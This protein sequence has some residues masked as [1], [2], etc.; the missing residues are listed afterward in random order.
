MPAEAGDESTQLSQPGTIDV[1]PSS[2][3]KC[4]SQ[5]T[6]DQS[7]N[8]AESD[9]HPIPATK[10]HRS[11]SKTTKQP[12]SNVCPYSLIIRNQTSS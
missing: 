9:S 5:S 1:T 2:V 12:S 3:D 4:A 10:K 11:G 8:S 7:E 6:N